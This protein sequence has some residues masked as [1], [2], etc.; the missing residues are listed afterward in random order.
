M[1]IHNS[2]PFHP[3]SVS[4][5]Q[6][7]SPMSAIASI[8]V[9]PFSYL[10]PNPENSI[11]G[12][13]LAEELLLLLSR[14]D[15]LR[16]MARSSTFQFREGNT[17]IPEIA[18]Q[19][20]VGFV[21]EGK[22]LQSG[23]QLRVSCQLIE[24]KTGFIILS[25]R[26][27]SSFTDLFTVQDEIAAAIAGSLQLQFLEG[28]LQKRI[29]KYPEGPT[30][31]RYLLEGKH[32]FH[33]N[34]TEGFHKA[35][36]L[37]EK[38]L[39]LIPDFPEAK[40]GISIS[41]SRL[42]LR[43][44][45][46]YKS[47]M[48][49]ARQLALEAAKAAPD[50]VE[51][52]LA[53][54]EAQLHNWE[55]APVHETIHRAMSLFPGYAP[56]RRVYARYLNTVLQWDQAISELKL[57]RKLD[58]LSLNLQLA[59]AEMYSNKEDFDQALKLTAPILQSNPEYRPAMYIRGWSHF[60]KGDFPAALEQFMRIDALVPEPFKGISSLGCV[61]AVM[62]E[63]EKALE[64]LTGLR[65]RQQRDPQNSIHMDFVFVY[66]YLGQPEV[67]IEYLS[68]SFEE[69]NSFLLFT[70]RH[71]ALKPL[72][73]LPEFQRIHDQVGLPA[74]IATFGDQSFNQVIH[75]ESD[76]QENLHLQADQFVYA[77]AQ[78]NYSRIFWIDQGK[79]KS[80]LLRLTLKNLEL[81]LEEGQFLRCHRSFLINLSQQFIL[82][83]NSKQ[84]FLSLPPQ[85]QEIPVSRSEY[86]KIRE[87][88]T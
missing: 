64:I 40:S 56:V 88:F 81:Q 48:E 16:V 3:I 2:M 37:F 1:T 31:Y 70:Y 17:P 63:R 25:E 12:E 4:F 20:G 53:L 46:P 65:N 71:P 72:W 50:S 27:N 49:Q 10:G 14:I 6:S 5:P 57:A 76:T 68:K 32:A 21:L 8:A 19:L 58:P 13:G 51:P 7:I 38:A 36:S 79:L 28:D 59:I 42:S 44:Q 82:Q 67:A 55:F 33:Q 24:A 34:T 30:A 66:L 62:G 85:V 60:L 18:K 35:F 11:L 52:L 77:Q 73:Q 61:Y 80:H 9:L 29:R 78:D 86:P 23:Q 22:I 43:G 83:G 45:V 26:L 47:G 84:A 69:H 54:A 75:L 41:L 39:Q 15:G 74:H 87:L